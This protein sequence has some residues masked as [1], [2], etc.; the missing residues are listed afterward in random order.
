MNCYRKLEPMKWLNWLVKWEPVKGSLARKLITFGYIL[1]PL[2]AGVLV[3]AMLNYVAESYYYD[4]DGLWVE[5]YLRD[6]VTPG[7]SMSSWMA[8]GS[9]NYFP[10]MLVYGLVRIGVSDLKLAF[11]IFGAIKI[12]LIGASFY[13]MAGLTSSQSKLHR[14]WFASL[15]ATIVMLGLPASEGNT[16]LEPCGA[17]GDGL[18]IAFSCTEVADL[19]QFYTPGR[20]GGAYSNVLFGLIV[21][22]FWLRNPSGGRLWLMLLLVLSVLGLISDNL[23]LVWFIAPVL[24]AVGI[25]AILRRISWGPFLE[26]ASVLVLSVI[27]SKP[28]ERFFNP[29]RVINT[30]IDWHQGLGN[31]HKTITL[32]VELIVKYGYY[33]AVVV[34]YIVVAS[35]AIWVLFREWRTRDRVARKK[36]NE[37]MATARIF[38]LAFAALIPIANLTGMALTNNVTGRYMGG[39]SLAA[40]AIWLWLPLLGPWRNWLWIR[41]GGAFDHIGILGLLHGLPCPDLSGPRVGSD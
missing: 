22:L 20:H 2:A 5:D 9:P 1:A 4:S 23:F 29:I 38:L 8:P 27:I 12:L 13:I 33:Q 14:L 3:Y 39:V 25:L 35:I 37:L 21:T 19:W 30:N 17:I 7:M 41:G 11:I 16:L 28:I 36:N 10:E 31:V 24:Q 6:L 18:R 34:S 26:L 15:V 40:L 32:I